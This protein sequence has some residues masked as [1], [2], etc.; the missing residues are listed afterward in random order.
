MI[1]CL[2]NATSGAA[3]FEGFV[4]AAYV[5]GFPAIEAGLGDMSHY[6][7]V[8]GLDGLR[9]LLGER[10]LQI[11]STSLPVDW[12]GDEAK[13]RSQLEALPESMQLCQ[14]L[15]ITRMCT[16]VPPRWDV[17][18]DEAFAFA[19]ERFAAIADAIAPYSM[20]LGLEFVGPQG[21]F[22]RQKYKFT[23]TLAEMLHLIAAIG[24]DNVGL[25]LDSY[26]LYASGAT[27]AEIS[28]LPGR[29]VVQMHVNDAYVGV[30]AAELEDLKRL[31]PG[32]G[33]IPLVPMLRAL[34]STGYDW[35]VSVETF[36]VDL[37][38]LGPV[39]AARAAKAAIDS[40]LAV[41]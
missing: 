34:A 29:L 1:A 17:R 2:N 30:P 11:G 16:W 12:R 7:E 37:K 39:E 13:F 25:L 31:L 33:A 8:H 15:G 26:H 4:Q 32:E 10:Q 23:T 18:Y 28:S 38:A 40:V 14:A 24:R 3:S 41:L 20:R 5:A 35:T 19:R 27:L 6:A 21:G 22:A 36:S 9:R